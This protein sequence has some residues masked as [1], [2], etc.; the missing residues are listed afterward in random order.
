MANKGQSNSRKE[1]RQHDQPNAAG[2]KKGD[3][4]VFLDKHGN[5]R[6]YEISLTPQGEVLS[7]FGAHP[8]QITAIFHHLMESNVQSRQM[9]LMAA[10]KFRKEKRKKAILAKIKHIWSIITK[11]F[12]KVPQIEKKPQT[13]HVDPKVLESERQALSK[14][15]NLKKI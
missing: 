14:A 5:R 9:I 6:I 15:P 13:G 11:P 8:V 4:G 7:K 1:R 12:T 2:F 3:K 10:Q